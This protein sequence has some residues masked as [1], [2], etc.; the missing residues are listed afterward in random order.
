[1]LRIVKLAVILPTVLDHWG[2]GL[3]WGYCLGNFSWVQWVLRL[4]LYTASIPRGQGA[5]WLMA[6]VTSI[7]RHKGRRAPAMA[8]ISS[9]T[10]TLTGGKDHSLTH[11]SSSL[12]VKLLL[13]GSELTGHLST[14]QPAPDWGLSS[15]QVSTVRTL[16]C[17]SLQLT[18]GSELGSLSPAH[19]VMAWKAWSLL[20]CAHYYHRS[21]HS[22]GTMFRFRVEQLLRCF[23]S[24][25]WGRGHVGSQWYPQCDSVTGRGRRLINSR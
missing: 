12:S 14:R 6:W 15:A 21:H 23:S 19:R 18:L 24:K 8:G 20:T 10:G 3:H 4:S 9:V 25:C 2:V 22:V 13:H 11:F 17:R 5:A 1:M 16:G 7:R